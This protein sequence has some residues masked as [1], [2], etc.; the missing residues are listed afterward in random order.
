MERRLE[1]YKDLGKGNQE[2]GTDMDRSL[3]CGHLLTTVD[4]MDKI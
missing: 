4:V 3:C 2:D 1:K